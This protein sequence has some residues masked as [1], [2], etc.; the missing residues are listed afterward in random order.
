MSISSSCCFMAKELSVLRAISCSF[1]WDLIFSAL[2]GWDNSWGLPAS[3]HFLQISSCSSKAVL[4]SLEKNGYF[5][6]FCTVF[7]GSEISKFFS[8]D[9]TS[10]LEHISDK[11]GICSTILNL[12][13]ISWS[14]W[15]VWDWYP[16]IPD[17]CHLILLTGNSEYDFDR[18]R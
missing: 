7:L 4:C 8:A 10:I 2:A 5:L 3:L 12:L 17:S 1:L 16:S 11:T 18:S 15:A 13:N 9:I 6:F 14:I